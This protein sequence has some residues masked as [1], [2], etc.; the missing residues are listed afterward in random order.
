[1]AKRNNMPINNYYK[2]SALLVTILLAGAISVI[3]FGMTKIALSEMSIGTKGEE[4]AEAF[5]A[6]QAGTEDALMRFKFHDK[7]S[8]SV[9]E[10]ATKTS[11]EAVR[12]Y[13]DQE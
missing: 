11:S 5:Y 2:G 4:G 7:A 10:D 1:M 3:A 8:L 6:A 12:I 9:P 13:V